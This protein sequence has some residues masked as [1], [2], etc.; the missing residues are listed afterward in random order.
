MSQTK[1]TKVPH[2]VRLNTI[3]KIASETYTLRDTLKSGDPL[4]TTGIRSH[5]AE[6][7]DLN[8]RSESAA[9][10]ITVVALR[11][12]SVALSQRLN[13]KVGQRT[14]AA[15][16]DSV[17]PTRKSRRLIGRVLVAGVRAKSTSTQSRRSRNSPLELRH[18]PLL[19][20]FRL[21]VF[22]SFPI[23]RSTRT[24][25]VCHFSSQ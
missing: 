25:C 21:S 17:P 18:P 23:V 15:T 5:Q 24:M 13:C 14:Q 20:T 10:L 12:P 16:T 4:P 11:Q 6:I 2:P 19:S 9:A 8:L 3:P 7:I 1:M 22:I